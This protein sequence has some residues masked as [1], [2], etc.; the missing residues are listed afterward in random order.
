MQK[1]ESQ[2]YKG[3]WYFC[4]K[5]CRMAVQICI[6]NESEGKKWACTVLRLMCLDYNIDITFILM[7]Q[8]LWITYRRPMFY[9]VVMGASLSLS[10]ISL[11][12]KKNR[13]IKAQMSWNLSSTDDCHIQIKFEGFTAALSLSCIIYKAYSESLQ[14]NLRFSSDH[15]LL[16]APTWSSSFEDEKK[17]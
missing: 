6:N 3:N 12:K 16:T 9:V 17:K 11:K 13:R 14:S 10:F 1:A 2:H 5:H 7:C 15:P 4:S 8:L